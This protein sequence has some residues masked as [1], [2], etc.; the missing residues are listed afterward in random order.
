VDDLERLDSILS[1]FA[2][3]LQASD[4]GREGRLDAD[5]HLAI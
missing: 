3:V 1:A 4:A 2:A 5:L